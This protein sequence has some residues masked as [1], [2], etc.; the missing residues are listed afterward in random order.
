MKKRIIRGITS[1]RMC[2]E[3]TGDAGCLSSAWNIGMAWSTY[4]SWG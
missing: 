3:N 1:R 4:A 2:A